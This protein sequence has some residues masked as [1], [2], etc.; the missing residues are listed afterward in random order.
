MVAS[1]NHPVVDAVARAVPSP[2]NPV[3]GELITGKLLVKAA[4]LLD[5]VIVIVGGVIEPATL[6]VVLGWVVAPV[7]AI[8]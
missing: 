5:V 7:P 1:V 2:E 8:H 6:D 3:V 4:G